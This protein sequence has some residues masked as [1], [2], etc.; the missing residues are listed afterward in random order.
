MV[1]CGN[2]GMVKWRHVEMVENGFSQKPTVWCFLIRLSE[3]SKVKSTPIMMI[4]V[5]KMMMKMIIM[6][7]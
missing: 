7:L 5:M 4:M 6:S 1:K 3:D 2:V